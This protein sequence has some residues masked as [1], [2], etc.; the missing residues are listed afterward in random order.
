MARNYKNSSKPREA[1]APIYIAFH[2]EKNE[3]K[4]FWTRIQVPLPDDI[5]SAPT[6]R[7][8][9]RYT[10]PDRRRD[11]AAACKP[12]PKRNVESRYPVANATAASSPME[13]PTCAPIGHR[14]I[15][16][17]PADRTS[18]RSRTDTAQSM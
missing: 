18:S 11:A 12:H 10:L 16:S 3:D 6:S 15:A 7:G 8:E 17:C 14:V 13:I 4:S 5:C 9:L 2:V 1:K